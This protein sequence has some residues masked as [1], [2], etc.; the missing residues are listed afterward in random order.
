M[1][2]S[3]PLAP[4]SIEESTACRIPVDAM[5]LPTTA[6]SQSSIE[7]V[8]RALNYVRKPAAINLRAADENPT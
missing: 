7:S 5:I 2:E 4:L 1:T 8:R 6:I 3:L